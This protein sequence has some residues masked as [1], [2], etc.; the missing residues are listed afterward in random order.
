MSVLQLEYLSFFNLQLMMLTSFVLP[1]S[2]AAVFIVLPCS[3][4][5]IYA[6]CLLLIF[7]FV[8]V[9][10]TSVYFIHSTMLYMIACVCYGTEICIIFTLVVF[11][12]C[13]WD[14]ILNVHRV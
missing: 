12:L 13:L 3:G 5:Y 7:T 10:C 8:H 1:L 6:T 14:I 9:R 2:V 11:S 4:I